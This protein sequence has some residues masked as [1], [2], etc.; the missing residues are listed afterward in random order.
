[1]TR[2]IVKP[3][4]NKRKHKKYTCQ[5]QQYHKHKRTHLAEY[6]SPYRGNIISQKIRVKLHGNY[7]IG[8]TSLI[9]LTL[10]RG[11]TS[12]SV[13]H[14]KFICRVIVAMLCTSHTICRQC[15]L[16]HNTPLATAR[17][18][19]CLSI[20]FTCA[21]CFLCGDKSH[22]LQLRAQLEGSLLYSAG[23]HSTTS[24]NRKHV[25]NGHQK[26]LV[27]VALGSRNTGLDSLHK[28]EDGGLADLFIGAVQRGK[29]RALY[30]LN[31]ISGEL[32]E[33]E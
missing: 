13:Y 5:P 21:C 7:R 10:S 18:Y 17:V 12:N 22:N 26:G 14:L 28:L 15:T 6:L 23:G 29:G 31:I 30:N 33:G 11:Q 20:I 4:A 16:L 32:V 27:Q 25:L 9:F 19:V 2:T 1:M 8:A 24:G 3:Y